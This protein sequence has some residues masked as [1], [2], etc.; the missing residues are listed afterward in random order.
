[1]Y[2]PSYKL[3]DRLINHLVKLETDR[4]IVS[5]QMT[6]TPVKARMEKRN[7]T[8]NLFHLA[9]MLDVP[10]TLKEAEK[11]A[12]GKKLA[13]DDKKSIILN[14]FRNILEFNRSSVAESYADID[15]N[16][17]NH[18]NKLLLTDWREPWEAK[19]RIGDENIDGDFDNWVGLRDQSLNTANLQSE[20][21]AGLE[22]YK[23]NQSLVF[24]LIRI[25]VLLQRFIRLAPFSYG[26]KL[27]AIALADY[28]LY[29]AGYT[30]RSFLPI[31]RS[32][33]VNGED[34]IEALVMAGEIND[35]TIWIERFV[36]NLAVDMADVREEYFNL[37]AEQ[38]KSTKQPFLDLNKRQLKI[39]RYLQ[40]IPTVRREDYCQ[41]ME[42]STM[43]AFRD[44]TDLVTKKLIKIEGQGR[45]TKYMLYNR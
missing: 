11:L 9:H 38:E 7:K 45:G 10:I 17:L 41:M 20:L 33:D 15:L 14:N 5:S 29:R 32:F 26:N 35:V 1:M 44:L 37:V 27:T 4:T 21:L 42:V 22:W 6:P 23:A 8:L 3:T 16:L 19:I 30:G 28:L 36:R 40:T 2:I 31:M 39:L 34:Y 12:E 13:T 18:L 25:G 24:V 43:T